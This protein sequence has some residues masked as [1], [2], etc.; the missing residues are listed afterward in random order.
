MLGDL[1][2]CGADPCA[3]K[4]GRAVSSAEVQQGGMKMMR[5]SAIIVFESSNSVQHANEQDALHQTR[6][7]LLAWLVSG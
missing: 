5:Q 1:R 4:K 2:F 7:A 3:K 6:Y